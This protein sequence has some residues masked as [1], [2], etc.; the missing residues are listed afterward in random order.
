MCFR[1]SVVLSRYCQLKKYLIIINRFLLGFGLC[2]FLISCDKDMHN[3]LDIKGAK[4]LFQ[5]RRYVQPAGEEFSKQQQTILEE[6]SQELSSKR[7]RTLQ[8]RLPADDVSSRRPFGETFAMSIGDLGS[9]SMDIHRKYMAVQQAI[10]VNKR[11]L[12]QKQKRLD[13]FEEEISSKMNLEEELYYFEVEKIILNTLNFLEKE[14]DILNAQIVIG[15]SADDIARNIAFWGR[16]HLGKEDEYVDLQESFLFL[17]HDISSGIAMG[18]QKNILDEIG[19]RSMNVNFS[20][21]ALPVAIQSL[22]RSIDMSVYLSP[23]I[24]KSQEKVS[25]NLQQTDILDILDIIIDNY[26]VA[27]AYDKHM[28]VARFYSHHELNQHI[29]TAIIAATNHN[30]KASILKGVAKVQE[31][32]EELLSF[33]QKY[34]NDRSKKGRIQDMGSFLSISKDVS[35][36]ASETLFNIKKLS[37]ER[38]RIVNAEKIQQETQRVDIQD[39]IL[40]LK[41][42]LSLMDSRQKEIEKAIENA[43]LSGDMKPHQLFSNRTRLVETSIVKD[44]SLK[45]TEPVYTDR[46][47]IYYQ[48]PSA[49]E[50][51]ISSYFNK[52][53]H[54]RSVVKE[55]RS[56]SENNDER[57]EN[58]Q[59][60]KTI[61]FDDQYFRPPKVNIDKTAIVITGLKTDID[62]A[63]K[64]IEDFDI[65]QKQV[66]VEVFMVNVTRNW[67]RKL[68]MS[69]ERLKGMSSGSILTQSGFNFATNLTRNIL[70]NQ[71]SF[72]NKSGDLESIIGFMEGQSIGRT[73][74]SPTILAKDMIP[75]NIN[76]TVTRFR[77]VSTQE[78]TGET[79]SVTGSPIFR[80]VVDY[81]PVKATLNLSVTPTINVLND[82]V[83]LDISFEDSSF[84][85]EDANSSQL[86]NHITTSMD[87]APG[88]V[89]VLAGLYKENNARNREGIPF[90]SNIPIIGSLFNTKIDDYLRSDELVIFL[91]PTVITPRTGMI[92]PNMVQ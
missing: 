81:I 67:Q 62:L 75:A 86:S 77:A 87:A 90:I 37:F 74:S 24:Q 60:P 49:I 63:H 66:L 11:L 89:I 22:A 92:P 68:E 51:L 58:I 83:T 79:N 50:A 47:T 32:R 57:Q 35:S 38:Q 7:R 2:F 52:V 45:T 73:I 31:G 40:N 18:R 65:P 21:I 19:S 30:K 80:T 28:D 76:R 59:I 5:E 16:N 55:N 48:K 10:E 41:Q 44:A 71:L 12:S 82:H 14:V 29:T 13:T 70:N 25:L 15:L 42:E 84:L 6:R 78:P 1:V 46:F 4:A 53:Y 69:L 39:D 56:V 17:G 36:V 43:H 64:L 61:Q 91:A 26:D 23:M 27:L 20:N 3:S 34:F 54:T 33:Y 8:I 85:G 88:D 72:N 9:F